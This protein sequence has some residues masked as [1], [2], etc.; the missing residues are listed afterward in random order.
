M[1]GFIALL[2]LVL[3]ATIITNVSADAATALEKRRAVAAER[4]AARDYARRSDEDA[5]RAHSRD[6]AGN[7]KD[8]P[9]WARA[10]L[11]GSGSTPG[12]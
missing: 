6:P 12:R 7:Y 9:N 10:A 2:T 8:Y 3:A 11:G 1:A 5:A 4:A